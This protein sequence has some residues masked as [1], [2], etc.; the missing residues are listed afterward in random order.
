[1]YAR[2]NLKAGAACYGPGAGWDQAMRIY[3]SNRRLIGANPNIISV[4]SKLY[5][6]D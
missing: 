3:N 4:G 2:T 1:M 5:I 6:P